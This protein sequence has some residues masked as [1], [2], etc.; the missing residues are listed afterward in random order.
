MV[1]EDIHQGVTP[2]GS[3]GDEAPYLLIIDDNADDVFLTIRE[4]QKN[5]FYLPVEV[6]GN[7]WE[8]LNRLERTRRLPEAVLVN[9]RLP[10]LYGLEVI[11]KLREGERTR[12]LPAILLTSS[13]DECERACGVPCKSEADGCLVKP[14]DYQEFSGLMTGLELAEL[15][16]PN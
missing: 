3:L 15:R 11:E 6:A 13:E 4:L 9:H 1:V 2:M 12:A 10:G 14:L 8:A 16:A 7:G 5:G